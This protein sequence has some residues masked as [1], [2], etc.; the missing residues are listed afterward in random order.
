MLFILQ[1]SILSEQI[2]L[3]TTL[4]MP[5]VQFLIDHVGCHGLFF[6]KLTNLHSILSEHKARDDNV[7]TV[8]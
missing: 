4:W 8:L 5:A 2:L 6:V 1:V 3:Y 7:I